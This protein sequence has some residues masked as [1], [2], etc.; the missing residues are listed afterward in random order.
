MDIHAGVYIDVIERH[1]HD[2]SA[3]ALITTHFSN[4][5]YNP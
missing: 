4:A 5:V 3:F 2:L 1:L